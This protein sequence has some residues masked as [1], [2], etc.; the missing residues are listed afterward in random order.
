ML[1]SKSNQLS[2]S[3]FLIVVI[4]SG[5][6]SGMM[7]H[8]AYISLKD[9][10]GT[11]CSSSPGCLFEWS[12][13]Q[14]NAMDVRHLPPMPPRRGSIF[15][16]RCQYRPYDQ[17]SIASVNVGR[18]TSTTVIYTAHITSP[19]AVASRRLCCTRVAYHPQ[20]RRLSSS[21]RRRRPKSKGLPA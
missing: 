8:V 12:M 2:S 14:T 1:Q 21:N 3:T 16:T 19:T 17:D 18:T 9:G 7:L 5:S 13:L 11:L 10:L 20:K 15:Y 4:S 6:T